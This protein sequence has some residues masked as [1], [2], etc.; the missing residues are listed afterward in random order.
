MGLNPLAAVF[1]GDLPSPVDLRVGVR[2]LGGAA[3][4]RDE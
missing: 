3:G 4:A 2:C 1:F